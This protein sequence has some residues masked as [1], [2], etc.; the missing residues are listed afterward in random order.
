MSTG[1]RSRG[2]PS[3]RSRSSQYFSRSRGQPRLLAADDLAARP[4][5][6][7][8]SQTIKP[9]PDP[10]P[11]PAI[12]PARVDQIR[13]SPA[14]PPVEGPQS[15]LFA[16]GLPA[17]RLTRPLMARKSLTPDEQEKLVADNCQLVAEALEA[18]RDRASNRRAWFSLA[19]AAQIGLLLAAEQF[20]PSKYQLD[21][22]AD[23]AWPLIRD[24]IAVELAA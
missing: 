20:D 5:W 8:L 9:G 24:E 14:P 2:G 15:Q 11:E 7:P 16:A 12:A 17:A 19:Q 4:V 13:L 22:F 10:A 6:R 1:Y 18:H 23:Y 21:Q 3:S